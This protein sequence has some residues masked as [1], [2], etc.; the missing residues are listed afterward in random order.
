MADK[1]IWNEFLIIC[2]LELNREK[3]TKARRREL[4]EERKNTF[5]ACTRERER[6]WFLES[7]FSERLAERVSPSGSRIHSQK[8]IRNREV[9]LFDATQNSYIHA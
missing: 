3:R 7:P 8:E 1:M 2:L 6:A 5:P 9:L 4:R